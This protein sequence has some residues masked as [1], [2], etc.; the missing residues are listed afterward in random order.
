[1]K[2]FGGSRDGADRRRA[3]RYP[4]ETPVTYRVMRGRRNLKTGVGRTINISSKAL[5]LEA[6]NPLPAG[7]DIEVAL[8]W[9]AMLNNECG[10]SLVVS[11]KV[12]RSDELSSAVSIMRYQFRTRGRRVTQRDSEALVGASA[13]AG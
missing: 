5:L 3:K 9:P 8:E 6:E 4:I 10:L 12:I 2:L 7:S 11:G 13:S 1:M